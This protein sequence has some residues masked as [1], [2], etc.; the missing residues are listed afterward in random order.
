MPNIAIS[1]QATFINNRKIEKQVNVI[2]LIGLALDSKRQPDYIFLS[3]IENINKRI[4]FIKQFYNQLWNYAIEDCKN[5]KLKNFVYFYIGTG[6]FSTYIYELTNLNNEE[7][8]DLIIN[9]LK[10]VNKKTNIKLIDGNK[11]N[12]FIPDIFYNNKYK[13]DYSNTLF[14]NAWDPWSFVGNGNY[15]DN[16]LDGY[17]GRE[18]NLALLCWP[19]TNPYII[20]KSL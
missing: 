9:E 8:K 20:M 13:I 18:S 19:L 7:Y 17:Y 3:N 2:N 16:S 12:Y 1:T 4:K 5:R 15:M 10:K 6:A 11:K 14:M